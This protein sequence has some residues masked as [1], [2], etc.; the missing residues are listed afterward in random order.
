[1]KKIISFWLPEDALYFLARLETLITATRTL[2]QGH[3]YII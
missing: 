3:T 1:V 2:V